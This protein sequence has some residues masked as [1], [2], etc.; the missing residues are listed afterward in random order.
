M[1]IKKEKIDQIEEHVPTGI[2]VDNFIDYFD[3]VKDKFK[4]RVD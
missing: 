4:T 3:E 1:N 2:I